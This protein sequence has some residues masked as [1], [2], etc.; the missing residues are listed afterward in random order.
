VPAGAGRGKAEPAAGLPSAATC[1]TSLG[2]F[3]KE[4]VIKSLAVVIML[5]APV[6]WSAGAVL[7]QSPTHWS[8]ARWDS[9]GL[10]PDPA[11]HADAIVQIYAART[12]GWRGVFAVHSWLVVKRDSAS[13]YERYEV[14]GWGVRN[15]QPAVR[16]NMRPADGRW[17]GNDPALLID[18]RGD[19][20]ARAIPKID[21]A[22][23]AY[24]YDGR[25][26]TWPG[27]NSNSFVA[28]IV[29][30]VPEL[31]TELP[32]TAIG[33]DFFPNGRIAAP[34]LSGT[35]FQVSLAGL[36]GF[37]LAVEEGLEINLLGLVFGIDPLDLAVK[38]PGVGRIGVR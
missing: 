1:P 31:A 22:I 21:A 20:A 26:V 3:D 29:R 25:Y 35:G 9:T 15:G 10:A 14:V 36:L 27:P 16:R 24:P 18:L 17:A 19:P 12:W 38:L 5:V 34:A 30:S 6:L 33:K 4:L 23:A 37:T 11:A 8:V 2:A 7:G 13:A 28:H 32:P